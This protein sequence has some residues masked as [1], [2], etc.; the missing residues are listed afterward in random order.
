MSA[1]HQT[2]AVPRRSADRNVLTAALFQNRC[3]S[4]FRP[5][6]CNGTTTK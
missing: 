5:R 6:R 3:L 4:V 2:P 1:L